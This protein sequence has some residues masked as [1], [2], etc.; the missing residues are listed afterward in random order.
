M[1]KANRITISSRIHD[2]LRLILAGAEFQDLQKYAAEHGWKV[3]ERQLRRYVEVAHRQF[4][5]SLSQNREQLLGR[6]LMQRRALYARALKENDLRTA[7]QV[8]RDEAA[9]Q[10]LYPP[11]K[12]APTT[13][14]GN[15]P[16]PREQAIQIA[17]SEMT[18]EELL[19]LSRLKRRVETTNSKPQDVVD[20]MIAIP[21][22]SGDS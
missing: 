9:L 7:L 14:D 2:V 13:P 4:A 19:I 1:A 16:Y 3:S 18:T 20:G 12:I 8:L 15:E 17:V 10:N 6:H 22:A 5:E 21:D 11:T